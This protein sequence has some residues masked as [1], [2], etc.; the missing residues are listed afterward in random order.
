[1][2]AKKKILII[3]LN[4][5][6]LLKN[7]IAIFP[8]KAFNLSLFDNLPK[9]HKLV[10][11]NASILSFFKNFLFTKKINED[12]YVLIF[13]VWSTG[14]HHFVT[15]TL[16]KAILFKEELKSKIIIIPP[17]APLFIMES[18]NMIHDFKYIELN[19]PFYLK[20]LSFIEN[21][22]SGYYDQK[23]LIA[24]K[25]N[26]IPLNKKV[27]YKK[28]YLSREKAR[29]RKILNETELIELLKKYQFQIVETD[30]MSFQEQLNLFSESNFLISP[31]GAG[32]TNMI[33][34]DELSTIIE[35]IPEKSI[36]DKY[37]YNLCYNRMSK[38]LSYNYH[39][40]ICKREDNRV[41]FD[42]CNLII[43]L[44]RVEN[45]ISSN[46]N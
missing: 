28:I 44:K 39:S 46:G 24:L 35:I 41:S 15:E 2:E 40:I 11:V 21:P 20:S 22:N 7:F 17:N 45:L 26:L 6:Y 38:T 25:S 18:L 14:Y 42:M 30:N 37:D 16:I 8:L 36:Y 43:D 4:K 12:N 13:N 27:A 34:M 29:S 33:F 3:T 10:L 31:H 19:N 23:Q 32:L 1:M 5:V 9:K